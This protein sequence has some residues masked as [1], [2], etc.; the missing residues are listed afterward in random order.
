MIHD[1]NSPLVS[2][3]MA[4]YNAEKFL[5]F[6]I[7]SV[8][9]QTY[10]YWELLIVND[11]SNDR[12]KDVV[13]SFQD[14]RIK[15]INLEENG[16]AGVARNIG[17]KSARGNFIAFLDADDLWLPKKLETQISF[18]QESKAPIC[19]TS[20]TFINESGDS[21][22]GYVRASDKVD[23]H[24]YMR[25]TEIGLSTAMINKDIIGDFV[26]NSMRLRQD[27]RLWIELL[28][29]NFQA[30]GLD[31]NLVQYRIREG[32]ISGNKFRSA[33]KTFRLYLSFKD[34]PLICRLFNFSCYVVNAIAKR[35]VRQKKC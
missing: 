15:L 4:A 22:A 24:K 21:I 8:M 20:Y 10:P 23:L 14:P 17:L 11:C 12:T 13:N 25:N 1:T 7:A 28:N 16:G 31:Q 2:V 5:P 3:I 32:Q 19:H 34:I 9:G 35:L 18:M 30:F 6:S 33:L 29:R 26:F 27:T